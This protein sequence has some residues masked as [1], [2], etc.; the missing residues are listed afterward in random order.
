M[1]KIVGILGVGID[2]GTFLDWSL[3]YLSGDTY[4]YHSPILGLLAN[5]TFNWSFSKIR[6]IDNPIMPTKG[7]AHKHLKNHPNQYTI[8]MCINKMLQIDDS[9]INFSSFYNIDI[10]EEGLTYDSY[11]DRHTEKH[12]NVKFIVLHSDEESYIHLYHRTISYFKTI[13]PT[14]SLPPL[15]KHSISTLA[16]SPNRK[17]LKIV[18]MYYNLDS[19]IVELMKWLDI[20]LKIDR[21]ENWKSIYNQWK[22]MISIK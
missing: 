13:K 19:N 4:M 2:G 8:D 18:D 9:E 16:D 3:H 22:E 6:I 1:N 11:I 10:P 5:N 15:S 17:M 20:E 7:I 12:P 14:H 21:F